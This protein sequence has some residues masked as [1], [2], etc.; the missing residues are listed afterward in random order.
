MIIFPV[1]FSW[2]RIL[3][4][5]TS[6]HCNTGV[7]FIQ[8]SHHY[9]YV[10]ISK[11]QQLSVSNV[12]THCEAG[13][14]TERFYLSTLFVCRHWF[15]C[16][17]TSWCSYCRRGGDHVGRPNQMGEEAETDGPQDE[18]NKGSAES[19]LSSF[20]NSGLQT[21]PPGGVYI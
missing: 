11:N 12:K 7:Y 16:L 5:D 3:T 20:Q 8:S 18:P 21:C 17:W 15:N 14:V 2:C 6:S 1:G 19:A 10:E 4:K 13:V 9:M